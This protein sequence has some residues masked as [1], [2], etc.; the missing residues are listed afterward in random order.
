MIGRDHVLL[1]Q[2]PTPGPHNRVVAKP[3]AI[4][5]LGLGYIASTLLNG[6]FEVR[7]LDMDV[8]DIDVEELQHILESFSPGVVGISTTTLSF[9]NSLRVAKVI[10]QH[11]PECIICLGGPHV[12]VNYHEA[13]SYPFVNIVVRGEGEIT[14]L[15]VCRSIAK[16][17]KVPLNIDGTVVR[18]GNGILALPK[19]P[20]IT[21]LDELL[22]PA[23]HLMP[24]HLYNI[25]GTILTSRG[26]PFNCGFCAGP[27]VMG[28]KY[29]ARSAKNV[30]A[31]VQMCIDQFGITSFYFVD[32]TMTH[33][34]QR[35]QDICDGLRQIKIP[36]SIGRKLKWT[37]ESRADVVTPE[38]L[39][40]MKSAGCTTIQFGMESGS[41][42]L[43]NQLGKKI[44]LKQIEQAVIWSRQ[45]GISTV[46]SMVFPHPNETEQT[47]QQTFDFIRRLYEVGAE[48]V[49][50][51][52][53]TLFPGTR[54]MDKRDELGLKLLTE[55]TDEYNLGT[56]TLTTKHLN[57]NAIA[58]GYS[59]LLMLTQHLGG[60][61]IGGIGIKDID[62]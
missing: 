44:T 59:Q 47:L 46:L 7:I 57:L 18:S 55:D 35:L 56:L 29:I 60:D 13:L 54:F 26:C 9:K 61:E 24:L 31:E 33:D 1:L 32:D 52:L 62:Y 50:P 21:N 12:T 25:P 48:K 34:T 19:R 37:C 36:S 49:I 3:S 45:A 38:I 2:A 30:V 51:A 15:E 39:Q 8:E 27:V 22:F 58:N 20:R 17:N 23:R 40:D 41:Q 42:E 4:P 10:K 6:G 11:L 5:P 16:K 14:F 43:L 28:Q 53:L